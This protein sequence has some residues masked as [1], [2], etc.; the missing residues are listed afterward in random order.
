[1]KKKKPA[2]IIAVLAAGVIAVAILAAQS[3]NWSKLSYEAV[4][5]QTATMPD[6]EIR[7]IVERTSEIYADTLNSL[8]IGEET[9]LMDTDGKTISAGD[10]R[11]GMKVR[12]TLK[13]AFTEETP[14]YYPT[15]YEVKIIK[16]AYIKGLYPLMEWQYLS[17]TTGV[18]LF[19]DTPVVL[20]Y[21]YYF[22]EFST[23]ATTFFICSMLF[24]A[25][26]YRPSAVSKDVR[27]EVVCSLAFIAA[28]IV[29]TQSAGTA[30]IP[31]K[32]P[33]REP[34]VCARQSVS[35]PEFTA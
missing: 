22:R 14:F 8:H 26:R 3:S 10:L 35:R 17:N 2:V 11:P 1:M 29:F 28:S 30:S 9:K 34:A 23:S 13:D 19:S 31:F 33:A 16:A 5:R 20:A 4:V 15:V 12:I 21:G 27:L 18:P 6:G 24:M 25:A 32:A 7:L